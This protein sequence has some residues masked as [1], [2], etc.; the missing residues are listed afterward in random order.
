[1]RLP[2]T[3]GLGARKS[4]GGAFLSDIRLIDAKYFAHHAIDVAA[5]GMQTD[6]CRTGSSHA[7]RAASV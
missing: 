1:M 7:Q 6:I 2:G 4:P 5:L 3:H